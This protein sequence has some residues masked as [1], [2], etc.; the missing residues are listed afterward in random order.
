M[1][2]TGDTSYKHRFEYAFCELVGSGYAELYIYNIYICE[3]SGE[4]CT[5]RKVIINCVLVVLSS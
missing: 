5:G 4:L 3:K 1:C 2:D